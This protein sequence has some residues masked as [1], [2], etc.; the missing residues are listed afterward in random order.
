MAIRFFYFANQNE[1]NSFFS[2]G[3]NQ[4][5]S[6]Y[7]YVIEQEGLLYKG[8]K[9]IAQ[10]GTQLFNSVT[11]A[12]VAVNEVVKDNTSRIV[13]IEGSISGLDERFN[14]KVDKIEGKGLSET[15]FTQIEKTKLAGIS[16][17]ANKII[18]DS[19]LSNTSE[20]PVQN[21]IVK[22][23][24]DKKVSTSTTVNGQAL[25]DDIILTHES[26]GADKAGTASSAVSTHNTSTTA[27]NDIRTSIGAN[28]S[29]ISKVSGNLTAHVQDAGV[30]LNDDLKAKITNAYTY[31]TKNHA[32][33]AF[34]KV[35]VGN[36]TIETNSNAGTLTLVAG[37]GVT[38]TPD[39]SKDT[40]T[41]SSLDGV[42]E[43]KTGTNNGAI[44]VDGTDIA[45]KG[46]KSAAYQDSSDILSATE[47]KASELISNH[48]G[49]GTHVTSDQKTTWTNAATQISQ[50]EGN[51]DIHVGTGEK[52]KWNGAY[53]HS[54]ST[55]APTDARANI[56]ETIKVNNTALTPSNK[57]VNI[58]VPTQASD[59]N[60]APS[61]HIHEN[62]INQNSFSK[63][64]VGTT[65]IEA[66]TTTDTLEFVAGTGI[67]ITPNATNNK[68]TI[69][70]SGVTSVTTGSGNGKISVNGSDVAV[71]GLG[72]AAYTAST[73]YDAAGTAETKANAAL[74]SAKSYTDEQVAFLLDNST[75]AVDSIKELAEAM[76]ENDNNVVTSLTEAIGKKA[77]KSHTHAIS[78]ITSLQSSL[79]G[80]VS[81]TTTV[82]GKAL[83]GNITLSAS[84]VGAYSKTEIDA[85]L[86]T[87]ALASD[88]TTHTGNANIHFTADE[89]TKL[90]GI[91]TGAQ[92]NQ[93]A[94]SN[95]K[96]GTSTVAADTKTD[97]VEFIGSNVTISADTTNDKVTFSVA[98][99]STSAKGIVK[100]SDATNSDSSAIAATSKAVKAAYDL[101]NG[102]VGSVSL[103]SGENN[104][105]VKIVVNGNANEV[106]VTGLNTAAFKAD[107]Y[108]AKSSHTHQYAASD[109]V[110]GAATRVKITDGSSDAE[111][112]VLVS[113]TSTSGQ[114]VYSVPGVTANYK[115]G[116]LTASGGFK[117][118]ADSAVKDSSGNKI[119]DTYSTKTEL[120]TAQST[121]QSNIDGKSDKN[122][123]HNYAG[124]SSAGGKATSAIDADNAG[125]ATV[126]TKL[127]SSATSLTSMGSSTTPVYFSDGVPV[128][129]NL[130]ITD[131]KVKQ[132]NETGTTGY[133]LLI[134]KTN[135]TSTKT[136]DVKKVSNATLTGT[137]ALQITSLKIGDATLSYDTTAG[138]L[139]ISF[140]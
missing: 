66:D 30:H 140:S 49:D 94:F 97:T 37:D 95:I 121:L 35:K 1:Y 82:N 116:T 57:T 72:S 41:I 19:A 12:I 78:D 24:L 52:D 14:S 76:A 69:T 42:R 122:H 131:N 70:N 53:E 34:T 64:K 73:A 126:A 130:T 67:N 4:I 39:A 29:E 136:E 54:T 123:T 3:V 92:V 23:E 139:V 128:E 16:E 119:T 98:D 102:K 105:T 61:S 8:N 47:G 55:H 21:K 6:D 124:S 32:E 88:L 59:I 125:L 5:N 75:E 77:D 79:N 103:T 80:K 132:T 112:S 115:L 15:D 86:A 108:F 106:D 89:R 137:G 9:L 135:T 118:Q 31:S 63:I 107:S 117:G 28:T 27:H 58:I 93:N 90:S 44:N 11:E 48:K 13:A 22:S 50:H 114:N 10:S 87:K 96:I 38:I 91:A 7:L 138:A 99:G 134:A 62:Y 18:I 74:A 127:G 83:S 65:S 101:A 110:G 60:A 113:S 43:I 40:I 45:V 85:S 68:V 2:N 25:S 26:V 33:K 46:L 84:D 17:G 100:L 133:P 104:G 20:N 109:D 129:C 81:T 36:T 51:T 111:R 71:K 56:I 120:T